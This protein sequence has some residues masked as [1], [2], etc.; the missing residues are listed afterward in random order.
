MGED[1]GRLLCRKIGIPEGDDGEVVVEGETGGMSRRLG[2]GGG[3]LEPFGD[4]GLGGRFL[5]CRGI[6]KPGPELSDGV[7]GS[8][9]LHAIEQY[10]APRRGRNGRPS[11]DVLQV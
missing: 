7:G 11:K 3:E 1:L 4:A 8:P 6:L 10:M 2:E 5:D 9:L